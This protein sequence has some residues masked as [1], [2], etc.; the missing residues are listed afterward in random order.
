MAGSIREVTDVEAMEQVVGL[1]RPRVSTLI[2]PA[3]EAW[4]PGHQVN[5]TASKLQQLGN[6][7]P[8]DASSGP[9]PMNTKTL[10]VETDSSPESTVSSSAEKQPKAAVTA[11]HPAEPDRC[12]KESG[13]VKE[14]VPTREL[15]DLQRRLQQLKLL[16]EYPKLGANRPR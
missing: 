13:P 6:V 9:T 10:V 5:G 3:E 14:V 8:N 7:P 4:T 15:K 12:D 11:A 16:S 2:D 1:E